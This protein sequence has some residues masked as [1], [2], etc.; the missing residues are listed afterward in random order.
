[1]TLIVSW[2]QMLLINLQL[3]TLGLRKGTLLTDIMLAYPLK[4]KPLCPRFFRFYKHLCWF[5][6]TLRY[7]SISKMAGE[8]FWKSLASVIFFWEVLAKLLIVR[9]L[10]QYEG[11]CCGMSFV[12]FRGHSAETCPLPIYLSLCENL[13]EQLMLLSLN[14][15][16][17]L[18]FSNC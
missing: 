14:P 6:L 7:T 3:L 8:N 10:L 16:C 1:M 2:N 18:N 11:A 13:L 15:F 12:V 5:Q 9:A 17:K 4:G